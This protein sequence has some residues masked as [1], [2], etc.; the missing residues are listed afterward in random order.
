MRQFSDE[1][2]DRQR[3]LKT[4]V[5]SIER[6]QIEDNADKAGMSVSAFIRARALN[7]TVEPIH[8]QT[9][10]LALIKTNADLGRLGG[11][12][13]LW[14]TTKPG[15]GASTSDVRQLLREIEETQILLRGL[16]HGV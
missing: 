7:W 9:A 11:L 10:V 14:L 6:I 13:K 2:R 15:E 1:S 4:F 12:L 3:P 16:I 8:N 5:T